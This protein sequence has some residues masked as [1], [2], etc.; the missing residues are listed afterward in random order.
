M[1]NDSFRVKIDVE[2]TTTDYF[3]RLGVYTVKHRKNLFLGMFKIKTEG[4]YEMFQDWLALIS[5]H[6]LDEPTYE[7]DEPITYE[8]VFS[9][10]RDR[11]NIELSEM[12]YCTTTADIDERNR[13]EV[14]I[15][16]KH[17]ARGEF[18]SRVRMF[19]RTK[20]DFYKL[21]KVIEFIPEKIAT[22]PPMSPP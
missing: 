7:L 14:R 17:R 13:L 12:Y 6:V 18:H 2:T 3:I 11:A 22:L 20:L 5:A 21:E 1:G 9:F 16:V 8:E 15:V 19:I 4:D 10:V